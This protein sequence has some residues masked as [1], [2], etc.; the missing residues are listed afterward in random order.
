MR[1]VTFS[2]LGGPE[3]IE[4]I[5]LPDPTASPGEVLIAVEAATINPA[6]ADARSGA[7]GQRIPAQRDGHWITGWDLA[8][9]ITA[10]GDGVDTSLVGTYVVGFSAW[11]STGVGTQASLVALPVANI[12]TADENIPAASLTTIGLNALTALQAIDLAGAAA[13]STLL[14]TGA[15]GGVGGYAVELAAQRGTVVTAIGAASDRET[16]L[17]FGATTFIKRGTDLSGLAVDAVFDPAGA[18]DEAIAAVRDGG[19]YVT[20]GAPSDPPRG[21]TGLAVGVVPDTAQLQ[22]LADLA[23]E[24]KLTMRVAETFD[25]ADAVAAYSKL[26][27]RGLRGR[28]V[29]TF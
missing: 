8:G 10:V 29:L 22:Q 21:I 12:A 19:V 14:V 16:L 26:T 23:A 5:D 20:A 9:H 4:T 24:G 1:A 18:G 17:G 13:G 15:A 27:E 25:A 6:D 2:T 11:F 28:V 7:F 3:V